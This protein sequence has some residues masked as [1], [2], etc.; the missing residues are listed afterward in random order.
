MG[1]VAADRGEV[2][3]A[4]VGNDVARLGEEGIV[5]AYRGM[6]LD[7]VDRGERPDA[8]PRR[9]VPGDVAH[10]ADL[11]EVDEGLRQEDAVLDEDQE[12]GP[13]CDRPGLRALDEDL[14][15]AV[16]R[17]WFDQLEAPH[18]LRSGHA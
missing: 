6:P 14:A 7:V 1:E 16:E 15:C 13:A 12:G 2:P 3:D 5:L 8:Q 18:L 17:L 11:A 10:A 9:G 4:D